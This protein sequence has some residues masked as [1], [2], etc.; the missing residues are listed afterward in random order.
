MVW[1]SVARHCSSHAIGNAITGAC[2]RS[3]VTSSATNGG[4]S[5]GSA[6]T[7][8]ARTSTAVAGAALPSSSWSAHRRASS[9]SSIP[10]VTLPTMRRRFSSNA[11]R[12]MMGTAHNSP[13]ESGLPV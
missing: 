6:F 1:L 12:S 13:K 8:S 9:R 4:L 10:A 7:R 5:A 3:L 2:P 11:R